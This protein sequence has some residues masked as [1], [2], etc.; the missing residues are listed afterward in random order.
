MHRDQLDGGRSAWI[1]AVGA[2]VGLTVC[3]GPAFIASFGLYVKPIAAEFGWSR[4]QVSAIYALVSVIGAV[5][6]PFL[7]F[8]LDRYGSRSI[9]VIASIL[10][11]LAL[12]TLPFMP[13]SYF[14][15]LGAGVV[16]GLVSIIASP[17]PYVSLLPQWFSARLGRAVAVAMFGSG[18]GQLGLA[19]IHGR[20]LAVLP[21]RTS[22]ILVAGLV[23]VVGIA[24]ALLTARDRPSVLA[25]RRSHQAMDIAGAPL[26]QALRSATFWTAALSFFL[27]QMVTSAMLTHLGP[28]LTDRGWSIAQ[29]AGL[30]GMI[31]LF[32]VAGR[33][34]SGALLD[35]YGFRPLGLL[36]FP[37]QGVGCLLLASADGGAAPFIAAALI[38]LG[39]GVE[40]DMLPWMLRR[41]FGLR[42]FGRLYG[43]AFGV[44]Q[45]GSMFGPLAMGLSFDRLGS[46]ATGLVFLASLSVLATLLVAI[47]AHYQ[48]RVS[49]S[50]DD[51]AA[52]V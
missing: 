1:V 21:W 26:G 36:I 43:I 40:A 46:Y 52:L 28:L 9:V 29:A 47:A 4:T 24:T 19:L 5:G 35:R 6:T 49:F 45:L 27:V 23:A 7:G 11:P 17:A 48:G 22:W 25:A 8:A 50:D 18:L 15:F 37:L 12:L 39:Y 41:T 34:L 33:A 30:V 31:G 2:A 44:V 32:S 51:R 3:F 13:P 16:L 38:G 10:L 14:A 20:L 42:C